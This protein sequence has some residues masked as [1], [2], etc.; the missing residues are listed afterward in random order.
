M[1]PR[2]RWPAV[3]TSVSGI[4]QAIWDAFHRKAEAS[5][6]TYRE[7]MEEAVGLLEA[8]V[9]AGKTIIWPHPVGGQSR[10]VQ[11]HHEAVDTVRGL[12]Q[13]LKL[14]QNVVFQAAI[15]RW[16]RHGVAE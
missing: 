13:E 3:A 7:A 14:R 6:L 8:A 5:G 11:M 16:L 15:E 2:V 1:S 9:R 12:A 4:D 10:P